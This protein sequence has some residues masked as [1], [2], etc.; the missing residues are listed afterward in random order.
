MGQI[1][2]DCK[3]IKNVIAEIKSVLELRTKLIIQKT[4]FMLRAT[5]KI[6]LRIYRKRTE[7]K[8]MREHDKEPMKELY[9][10]KK[11]VKTE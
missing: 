5:I 4:A 9:F 3:K 1:K 7:V 6:A 10:L 8:I 2:N 11:K